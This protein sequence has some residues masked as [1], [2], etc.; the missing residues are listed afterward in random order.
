MSRRLEIQQ[1]S[2]EEGHSFLLNIKFVNDREGVKKVFAKSIP[3]CGINLS[4][5][6]I[7]ERGGTPTSPSPFAN[8]FNP[9]EHSFWSITDYTDFGFADYG[10]PPS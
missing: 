1:D 6:K 2:K 7:T 5:N 9:K 8:V 3:I 10:V 4:T